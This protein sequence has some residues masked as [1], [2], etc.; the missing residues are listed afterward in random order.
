[1]ASSSWPTNP[2]PTPK[3]PTFEVGRASSSQPLAGEGDG[4]WSPPLP[5]RRLPPA[6]GWGVRWVA[7]AASP[8]LLPRPLCAFRRRRPG[9]LR[10]LGTELS[11]LSCLVLPVDYCWLFVRPGLWSA[12]VDWNVD[13]WLLECGSVLVMEFCLASF[14]WKRRM[15][16]GWWWAS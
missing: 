8:T 4:R 14:L 1:M 15:I 12:S 2:F 5:P 10:L 11:F 6:A 9:L 3:Q 13:V 7:A 16:W